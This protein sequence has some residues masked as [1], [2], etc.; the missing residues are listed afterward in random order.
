M[1]SNV[2][3]MYKDS[4]PLSRIDWFFV[5]QKENLC[6]KSRLRCC[7]VNILFGD[8]QSQ[9]H[10]S[11]LLK[12]DYVNPLQGTDRHLEEKKIV[13]PEWSREQLGECVS[14]YPSGNGRMQ[15]ADEDVV[16]TIAGSGC[17]LLLEDCT[18]QCIIEKTMVH[19]SELSLPF[20]LPKYLIC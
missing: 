19:F 7:I 12:P 9:L 8:F 18:K 6:D 20:V 14:K 2:E 15:S 16:M 1:F 5:F 3:C 4:E 17:K 10:C 11:V 13:I